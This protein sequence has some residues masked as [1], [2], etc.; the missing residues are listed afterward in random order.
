[1]IKDFLTGT[2]YVIK[3]CKAFYG[4][5]KTWKYAVIPLFLMSCV[6][7]FAFWYIL[8][9][10]AVAADK[11]NVLITNLPSWLTWLSGFINGACYAI[12]AISA[13]FILAATVSAFYEIFGSF[14]FDSLV[15][16]YEAQKFNSRPN[17]FLLK[18]QVKY[19]LES[20]F[21]GIKT[22]SAFIL[23]LLIS[24]FFPILGQILLILST[25]YNLGLSYMICSANNSGLSIRELKHELN[26]KN[27]NSMLSGFGVAA[28]LL[29]LIPFAALFLLPGLVLGGAELFNTQIKKG[30]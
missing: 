24:I 13:L 11:I 3:G 9:Y 8:H 4:N 16:Y 15:E 21:F 20:I 5:K 6:Y 22:F 1:M 14:F 7:F 2:T 10:A 17:R 29:L 28:Y 30:V 27:R 23:I 25:G 26:K 12:G 19:A 18:S